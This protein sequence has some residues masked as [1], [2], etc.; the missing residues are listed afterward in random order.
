MSAVNTQSGSAA[1]TALVP[2]TMSRSMPTAARLGAPDRVVISGVTG[3]QPRT[4]VPGPS[5]TS[6]SRS[7]MRWRGGGNGASGSRSGTVGEPTDGPGS[8]PRRP[9]CRALRAKPCSTD[10]VRASSRPASGTSPSPGPVGTR[11]CPAPGPPASIVSMRVTS[12]AK[13]WRGGGQIAGQG[14]A[15]VGGEGEV[16]QATDPGVEHPADPGVD[17]VARQRSRTSAAVDPAAVPG[18]LHAHDRARPHV[19]GLLGRGERGEA[20]VEADR[21]GQAPGQLDVVE[22]VVGGE[23][24][25]EAGEAEIVELLE[26]TG[27]VGSARLAVDA[28]R[29]RWR[30]PSAPAQ[31]RRPRARLEGAR[32]HARG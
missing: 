5:S 17:A 31:A 6:T 24:L 7:L 27:V 8:P 2:P 13:S 28:G 30:R 10:T 15:G 14:G 11:R 19:E 20:L 4:S 32:R 12:S 16:G 21:G 22:Q 23:G 1:R 18:S 26:A 29:P 3:I 9:R 25:F